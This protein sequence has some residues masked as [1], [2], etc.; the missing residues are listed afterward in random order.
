M[1]REGIA[2]GAG[3]GDEGTSSQGGEAWLGRKSPR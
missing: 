2:A 3:Q 1:A